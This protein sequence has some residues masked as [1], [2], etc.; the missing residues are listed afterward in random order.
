MVGCFR[1]GRT[2]LPGDTVWAS[3]DDC[4]KTVGI[5]RRGCA[6]VVRNPRWF[7]DETMDWHQR[8]ACAARAV[9]FGGAGPPGRAAAP[10]PPSWRPG[11]G[12]V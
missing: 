4:G 3:C 5:C 11:Q 1:C 6:Q 7:L 9:T 10:A 12:L 2:R 8:F